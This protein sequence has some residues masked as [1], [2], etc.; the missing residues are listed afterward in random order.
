L[1]GR[2]AELTDGIFIHELQKKR[3][4]RVHSDLDIRMDP[5]MEFML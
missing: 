1:P 3:I 2:D 5:E 4:T